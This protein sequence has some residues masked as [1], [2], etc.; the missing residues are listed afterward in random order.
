MKIAILGRG[1]LIWCPRN[2]DFIYAGDAENT[3]RGWYKDGPKL[4]IEFARVSG[5]GN[6]DERLTLV[7]NPGSTPVQTLWAVAK[8]VSID[9]AARN[10]NQREGCRR[11]SC[12]AQWKAGQRTVDDITSA[13]AAWAQDRSLDA[14]IWT[15][16]C[17]NKGL[18]G[19]EAA[20]VAYLRTRQGESRKASKE[21]IR[22]APEQIET[23][24]RPAPEAIC[25]E[26]D[27]EQ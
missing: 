19:D 7:L 24:F 5:E 8:A 2:L 25:D 1:S 10:L 26:W 16:L 21:Y 20:S 13:V 17:S 4:P 3:C 9:A 6:R 15:N 11:A 14:V 18:G 23:S 27:R 22:N 12:V